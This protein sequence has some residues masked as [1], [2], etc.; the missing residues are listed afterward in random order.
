METVNIKNT[1]LK[2][3]YISDRNISTITYNRLKWLAIASMLCDNAGLILAY[4][5][6]INYNT[7]SILRTFGLISYPIFAYL[8]IECYFFTSNK[9]KHFFKMLVIAI[10]SEVPNSI[11][12]YHEMP[13][14]KHINIVFICCI[15]FIMF[16]LI[17]IPYQKA[18]TKIY[19]QLNKH[20]KTVNILSFCIK[21]NIIAVITFISYFSL[22]IN[23][24][25]IAFMGIMFYAR[26]AKHYYRWLTIAYLV[27]IVPQLHLMINAY[28]YVF[29]IP[30]LIIFK[31][32]DRITTY[33][34]K[35]VTTNKYL[36]LLA[37]YNYPVQLYTLTFAEL[38][39]A[40]IILN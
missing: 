35:S 16:A 18:I 38:I 32:L 8:L 13:T 12:Y 4:Y 6:L 39:V 40:V 28:I 34:D 22:S 23:W 30:I 10:I 9:I 29:S 17:D 1:A 11:F 5:G 31:A 24:Y 36:T 7:Y 2:N 15:C 33:K 20:N 37:R 25:N 14:V 27:L 26:K 19:P 21:C 3:N